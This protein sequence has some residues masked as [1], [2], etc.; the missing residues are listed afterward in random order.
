[1]RP[2]TSSALDR[3]P[4]GRRSPF[5]SGWT[6]SGT[7]PGFTLVELIVIVALV[8]LFT[9]LVTPALLHL[10][11][12]HRVD[13]A[14]AEVMGTLRLTRARAVAY[15]DHVGIKFFTAEGGFVAP[16]S[17]AVTYRLFRDGDGDG[18][19]TADV[20]SGV[21][22]PVSPLRRLVHVGSTVRFGLPD[23]FVP[24]DPSSPS[25]RLR[26]LDDPIRFNRSDIASFGPLG[27][28]TPGSL[29]L[30]DG[31]SLA[32]VRVYNR[33]GKVRILRYDVAGDRWR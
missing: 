14:A 12:A 29:Y 24:R 16:G 25:R 8:G 32:V 11:S 5:P 23:G 7:A 3:R 10:S 6:S 27:S 28:S 20:L 22:P 18:L 17:T 4:Q 1:M 2:T 30:T 9:V 26:R 19:R 31:R 33:T 13:L 15:S 21:D